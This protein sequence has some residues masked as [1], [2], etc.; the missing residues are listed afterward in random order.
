MMR[1]T[2][3]AQP[4]VAFPVLLQACDEVLGHAV[5]HGVDNTAK[6]L[7]DAERFLSI[8]A[9]MRNAEAPVGF[10][11]NLLTHVSF[12]VLTIADKIDMMDILEACSGMAFT[13]TET[14]LRDVLVVVI[15]GTVRQWRDAIVTG[16]NHNQ[17]VLREGFNQIHNLFV[18]AG[19]ASVWNDYEQKPQDDGTYLLIEYKH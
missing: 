7:S 3:I 1:S 9:A 13:H 14:K 2:F 11:P 17:L 4:S 19:L 10:P 6:N 15:T 5:T 18:A 8:L 16:T 12:S